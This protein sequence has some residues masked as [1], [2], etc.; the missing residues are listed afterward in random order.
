MLR[1][2]SSNCGGSQPPIGGTDIIAV[3]KEL[4]Q[5]QQMQSLALSG[6]ALSISLA[7]AMLAGCG[8]SQPL[9]RASKKHGT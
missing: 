7:A 8:G 2:I 9:F 5:T 6:C 3:L 1:P 4:A